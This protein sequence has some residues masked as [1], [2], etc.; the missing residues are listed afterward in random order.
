MKYTFIILILL[1][2]KPVVAKD[3]F[4]RIT[5][6]SAGYSSQKLELLKQQ[7]IKNNS[8]SMLLLYDGKVFLNTVIFIKNT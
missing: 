3:S 5:P 2:L 8:S 7:L 1:F 6:E 4:E